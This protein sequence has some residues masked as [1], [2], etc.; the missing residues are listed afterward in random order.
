MMGINELHRSSQ[1][2]QLLN[3]LRDDI[4]TGNKSFF[5]LGCSPAS[6]WLQPPRRNV[7]K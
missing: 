5:L 2:D 4:K 6:V 7:E 1:R 3:I